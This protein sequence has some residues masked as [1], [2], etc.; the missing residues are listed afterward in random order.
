VAGESVLVDPAISKHVRA[1]RVYYDTHAFFIVLK[2]YLVLPGGLLE[3]V[4]QAEGLRPAVRGRSAASPRT[5]RVR[6]YYQ[7]PA[8][9]RSLR[10]NVDPS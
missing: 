4:A 1:I 8:E 7:E 3:I 5:N 2:A 9:S 10:D 6:L